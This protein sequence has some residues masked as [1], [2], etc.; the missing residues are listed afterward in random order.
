[1]SADEKPIRR[2]A[3]YTARLDDGSHVALVDYQFG[4]SV[5][6]VLE[7]RDDSTGR[8]RVVELDKVV[9]WSSGA[10]GS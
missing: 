9:Q 7:I 8:T 4:W 3:L 6:T 2:A 10:D 5:R 1:M